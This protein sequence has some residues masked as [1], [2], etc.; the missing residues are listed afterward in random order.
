LALCSLVVRSGPNAS[1][2]PDLFFVLNCDT[3]FQAVGCEFDS[4]L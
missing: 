4:R 2:R 3:I 1:T